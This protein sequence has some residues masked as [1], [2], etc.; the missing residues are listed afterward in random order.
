MRF[1]LLALTAVVI[2][3]VLISTEAVSE[4]KWGVLTMKA[5]RHGVQLDTFDFGGNFTS[6]SF[7][8]WPPRYLNFSLSKEQIELN[9]KRFGKSR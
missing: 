9:E 2:G 3:A 7:V 6:R 1:C 8:L 4:H 5:D